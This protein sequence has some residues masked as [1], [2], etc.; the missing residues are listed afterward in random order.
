MRRRGTIEIGIG[1]GAGD[2]PE[3]VFASQLTTNA[4]AT[5]LD[6]SNINRISG[7]AFFP[8]ET[9]NITSIEVRM[10]RTSE[11]LTGDFQLSIQDDSSNE[12]DNVDNG[13]VTIDATTL[14]TS[15]PGG[16]VRYELDTPVPCVASTKYWLHWRS[17]L[18]GATSGSLQISYW[19]ADIQAGDFKLATDGVPTWGA[20]VALDIQFI[21]NGKV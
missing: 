17:L 10:L 14:S 13:V 19:A 11:L 6:D 1:I 5:I 18:D 3:Q 16:F 2:V 8:T 21:I 4:T 12:P 9:G 7:Q 20:P 15:L